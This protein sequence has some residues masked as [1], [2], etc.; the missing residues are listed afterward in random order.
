MFY[1]YI[2]ISI[3]YYGRIHKKQ[4]FSSCFKEE[5]S[6]SRIGWED[7]I[8]PTLFLYDY[9]YKS[10]LITYPKQLNK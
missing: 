6:N 1:A 4:I 9:F 2:K 7:D 10:S 8:V 3:E 5:E